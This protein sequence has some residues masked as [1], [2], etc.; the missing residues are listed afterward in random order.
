M[1]QAK[2]I[3]GPV[4]LMASPAGAHLSGVTITTDGGFSLAPLNKLPN[5]LQ[6]LYFPQ[7]LLEKRKQRSASS[8]L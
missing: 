1:G 3:A 6:E 7:S 2:D 5:D 8:R 4:L